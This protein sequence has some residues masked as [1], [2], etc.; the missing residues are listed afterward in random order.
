MQNNRTTNLA[1]NCLGEIVDCVAVLVRYVNSMDNA[2]QIKFVLK[3]SDNLK[4]LWLP[5]CKSAPCDN[6]LAK[7][8]QLAHQVHVKAKILGLL[9]LTRFQLVPNSAYY[10]RVCYLA[11]LPGTVEIN[12]DKVR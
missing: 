11:D 8:E 9:Q 3:H 7:A 4:G 1:S 5:Y 12:D 6:W 10:A 2:N